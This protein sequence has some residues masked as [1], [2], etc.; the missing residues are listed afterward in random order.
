MLPRSP[1][2]HVKHESS[3]WFVV[4]G[5]TWAAVDD[6]KAKAVEVCV[7]PLVLANVDGKAILVVQQSSSLSQS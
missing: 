5:I 7:V 4:C 1:E 2:S 3:G 6:L